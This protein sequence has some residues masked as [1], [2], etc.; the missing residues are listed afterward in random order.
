MALPEGV[1]RLVFL[2]GL[3]KRTQERLA[4]SWKTHA[5]T[6]VLAK[7]DRKAQSGK[8][9][10][11]PGIVLGPENLRGRVPGEFRSTFPHN[12]SC[13]LRWPEQFTVLCNLRA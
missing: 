12:K 3:D 13:H 10:A 4:R 11:I 1:I 5:G 8:K 2:Q 9:G 6:E 7:G